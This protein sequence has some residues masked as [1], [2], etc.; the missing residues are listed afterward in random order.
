MNRG[1]VWWVDFPSPTGGEIQKRRPC[2]IISN[3]VS[4]RFLNRVQIIP[5]TSNVEK[6][7]AGEAYVNVGGKP[8]KALATQIQTASK[9][10]V[11][12]RLGR[13]TEFELLQVEKAIKTQLGI[14]EK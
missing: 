7:Q 3:D 10:R 4:N 11:L 9:E 5:L 1:E 12:N 2:V 6:L 13:L 14:K 8:G